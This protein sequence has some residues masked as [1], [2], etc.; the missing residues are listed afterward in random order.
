M[1]DAGMKWGGALQRRLENG[2]EAGNIFH[3]FSEKTSSSGTVSDIY[4]TCFYMRFLVRVL[5]SRS[6]CRS[7]A[8]GV[9]AG[10]ARASCC[11]WKDKLAA[12]INWPVSSIDMS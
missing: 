9:E 11:G 3:F 1:R 6:C 5:G 10:G 7:E 8:R 2:F 4:W 12:S